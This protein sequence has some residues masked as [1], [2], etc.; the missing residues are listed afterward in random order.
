VELVDFSRLV[1]TDAGG[2]QFGG[3]L[4]VKF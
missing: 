3:G 4:R 2:R 1:E